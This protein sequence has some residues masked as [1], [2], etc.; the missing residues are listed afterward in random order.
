MTPRQALSLL[1]END[2]RNVRDSKKYSFDHQ[3]MCRV[4]TDCAARLFQA[5]YLD[6]EVLGG[7]E[8]ERKAEENLRDVLEAAGYNLEQP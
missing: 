2:A 6:S 4:V 5:R 8:M 7:N 3:N 1:I